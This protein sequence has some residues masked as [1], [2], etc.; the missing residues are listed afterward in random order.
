M[1]NPRWAPVGRVEPLL[2]GQLPRLRDRVPWTP[3]AHLP[4]PVEHSAALCD[5]LGRDDVW[6]KRDDLVSPLYGG[7]KVRRF[8]YILPEAR[9]R[10]ATDLVTVGGLASTQVLA[11][12]LFGRESGFGVTGVLFDQPKT[13]FLREQ[14][15]TSAGAGG[16][17]V[18]GGG[19]AMTALRTMGALREASRPFLVLPGAS[20]PLY[21]L[22]YVDAL[23]ELA[24]QVRE[25]QLPRPDIIVTPAGSGGTVAGLAAGAALLGW[26][27]QVIGVRI[28]ERIA[29]NRATI[30]FLIR[31]TQRLLERRAGPD[32]RPRGRA[33]F[34]IDHRFAGRGY[35]YATP[36]AE[37][38]ISVAARMTG[39]EG[40]VTYSG[41]GLVAL[42]EIA[43]AHPQ[44]VILY[45]HTLSSAPRRS[46]AT[47]ES[48][49][50][51]LRRAYDA[52]LD[53]A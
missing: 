20:G 47:P 22:G 15:L 49:P 32:A 13:R 46:M 50:P 36:E 14:L 12:L 18:W 16:R 30:G 24:G 1:L 4:T 31:A 40:E 28:T 45:W 27:T 25:G 37:E 11:T 53:V 51:A 3:V 23:L 17:L 21:N 52:P 44:K 33:S 5:Y 9:A 26:S 19:Y 35:G 43:R 38:A 42:R 34:E 39:A 41:K 48:L 29:C 2:F 10:G 6:L 7:N 8:E